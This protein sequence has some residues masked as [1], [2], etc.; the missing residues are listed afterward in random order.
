MAIQLR[1]KDL[2]R[3]PVRVRAFDELGHAPRVRVCH[4]GHGHLPTAGRDDGSAATLAIREST[5]RAAVWMHPRSVPDM[6]KITTLGAH[7]LNG[8]PGY[9]F[10]PVAPQP[11]STQ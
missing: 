2:E 4:R 8:P 11:R 9:P 5:R 3:D 10:K 7:Y 1:C 6:D